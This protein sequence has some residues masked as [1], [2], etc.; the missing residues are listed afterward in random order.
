MNMLKSSHILTKLHMKGTHI[1]W[2][3]SKIE[4]RP[5]QELQ[6]VELHGGILQNNMHIGLW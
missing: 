1:K 4:P 3:L 2:Y 5:K 6:H